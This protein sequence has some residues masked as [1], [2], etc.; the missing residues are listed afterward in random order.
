MGLTQLLSALYI[1]RG[2]HRAATHHILAP[3]YLAAPTR[4]LQ[5]PAPSALTGTKADAVSLTPAAGHTFVPPKDVAATTVSQCAP[6]AA[7]PLASH[8]TRAPSRTSHTPSTACSNLF[9]PITPVNISALTSEL[10][11]YPD[12]HMVH[13]LQSGFSHGFSIGYTG[14]P[15]TNRSPN[16]SSAHDHPQVITSHIHTECS[17]GHTAGPYSYPPFTPFN[18][19]PLGVVPKKHSGKWRL[20][21]NLSYPPTLSVNDGIPIEEFSLKFISVDDASDAIMALGRGCHLAKVDIQSAFR[22]CPVRPADWHLLGFEWENSFYYD[23]VLPFGL[24]SAPYIFN[25]LAEALC[26]ILK[27]NYSL[28]H[29]MHYLDDFLTFTQSASEC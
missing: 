28:Q 3:A 8:L 22:I 2:Q 18:T 21:M 7:V 5:Y 26:W 17:L 4:K 23:R 16:L 20:I 6:C 19:S 13:Y 14:P 24:R 11:L 12:E 15:L 10:T 25:C 1:P 27:H 9:T 29:I